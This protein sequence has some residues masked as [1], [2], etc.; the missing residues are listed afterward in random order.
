MA[1]WV[2]KILLSPIFFAFWRIKVEG[3]EHVPATGPVIL[4][5]NHVSFLDSMFL[6][7][8]LLRR[9]TFVAKAEYFDTWK[10]AWFFRAAGRSRCAGKAA[11]R[12]SGPW[13]RP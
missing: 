10:T 8:V 5:P 1:Y 13:P 2:L 12:R 9:V 11:A 6:P 3:R 7:L 4:A